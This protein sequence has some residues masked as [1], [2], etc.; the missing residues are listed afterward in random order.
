M[1]QTMA[2]T[3]S[4][5]EDERRQ[6]TE[7]ETKIDRNLKSF[8]TAGMALLEIKEKKLYRETHDTFG[9]Y[10]RDRWDIGATHA[11]RTILAAQV[12]NNL[13]IEPTSSIL[14]A[15]E[16]QARPL[17]RLS[18]NEQRKAWQE[19]VKTA[20]DGKITYRHVERVARKYLNDG[21][22]PRFS[23]TIKPSDNW[24]FSPVEYKRE[25]AK[26]GHGYIPG[27]IYANCFWYY[28]RQGD[29]VVDPMAA[30]GI[31]KVVY[32]DRARWMGE[33][34]FDFELHLFDLSPQSPDVIQHDLLT[35]FP[36]EEADYIF[37]DPP[38]YGMAHGQYSDEP[39]DLANMTLEE[40][41]AAMQTIA[42]HCAAVQHPSTLC[43]VVSPNFRDIKT[44]QIVLLTEII[45]QVWEDAGY[46]LYDKA[47]ASRRIQQ[48]QSTRM[49][50][51]NNAAKANKTMLT[52][53]AEVLTFR[54]CD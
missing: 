49:A 51:V 29:V 22:G 19:A 7:L 38:Y 1:S 4:L 39:N 23:S 45:R 52:D 44:H 24:N 11:R 37:I 10:C 36:L 3:I 6:L 9:A 33:H 50:A 40:W 54:R 27:D 28:V 21:K 5:T 20:L 30:A 34:A 43:T 14:P 46:E 47:Y 53:I 48:K 17:T 13:R 15:N 41:T 18:P 2:I 26:D 31:A 32:D 25:D 8:L 16:R 35:R 12:V 42:E